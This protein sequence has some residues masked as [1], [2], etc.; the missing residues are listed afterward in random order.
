MTRAEFESLTIVSIG[1][2]AK[3][4]GIERRRLRRQMNRGH[5]QVM[6]T[7]N[8]YVI[9]RRT[10]CQQMPVFYGRLLE[11]LDRATGG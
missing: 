9:Y 3:L 2:L 6:R 4:S 11:R 5:V 10:L 1:C 8:R 7:G